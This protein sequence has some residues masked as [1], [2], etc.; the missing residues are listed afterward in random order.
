VDAVSDCGNEVTVGVAEL[1]E[2]DV[3]GPLLPL[4][5]ACD[6]SLDMDGDWGLRGNE[7]DDTFE[8]IEWE[9]VD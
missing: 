7:G 2:N 6:V 3:A 9:G 1:L 4:E 5:E 8:M